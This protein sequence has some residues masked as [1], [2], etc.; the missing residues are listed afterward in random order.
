[1]ELRMLRKNSIEYLPLTRGFALWRD[2]IWAELR[3]IGQLWNNLPGDINTDYRHIAKPWPLAEIIMDN[4]QSIDIFDSVISDTITEISI[5]ILEAEIDQLIND[6]FLKEIP[7]L[8]TAYKTYSLANKISERF[9][10]KKILKFL[11]RL[12]GIPRSERERFVEQ[13]QK[14]NQSKKVGEKLLIVLNR[15]DDTS[16]ADIIGK[17]YK[18]TI[19]NNISQSDFFRLASFIDKCFADDLQL[20]RETERS[21]SLPFEIKENFAQAGLFVRKIKD[22]R[23]QEEYFRSQ[24]GSSRHRV[25]PSFEYEINKYGELLVKYGL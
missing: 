13:L 3:I 21:E 9:F 19:Q 12:N 22:N 2:R 11:F 17:L 4:F 10:I 1:M 15:L 7:I 18:A 24:F 5:D 25:P 6:E 8:G 23:D 20:L 16:K 14:E